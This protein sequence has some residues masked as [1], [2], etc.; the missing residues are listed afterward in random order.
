LLLSPWKGEGINTLGDPFLSRMASSLGVVALVVPVAVTVLPISV[1]VG[2]AA[3]SFPEG[4]IVT[5][6]VL[7]LTLER[8]WSKCNKPYWLA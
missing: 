2:L 7:F 6:P 8:G 5:H 4:A 1:G 3:R